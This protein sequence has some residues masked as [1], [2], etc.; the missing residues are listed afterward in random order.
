MEGTL[1]YKNNM[2]IVKSKRIVHKQVGTHDYRVID[3]ETELPTHPEHNLWLKMFAEESMNVEFEVKTI[4]Q[5]TSELDIQDA[6]VA[7]LTKSKT[8][9]AL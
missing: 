6:D 8:V 4:A 9:K 5:G 7:W 1:H 3:T 2:W